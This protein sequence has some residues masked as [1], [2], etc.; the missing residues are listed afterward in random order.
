MNN[1]RKKAPKAQTINQRHTIPHL[2]PV[3]HTLHD[4]QLGKPVI[5]PTCHLYYIIP[6]IKLAARL[7]LNLGFTFQIFF[8][9]KRP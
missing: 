6:L 1:K 3:N 4:T 8:V 7:M 5:F 9:N 2:I